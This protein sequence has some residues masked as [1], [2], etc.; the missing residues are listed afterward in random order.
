[1]IC[2]YKPCI[3][4]VKEGRIYCS[5]EHSFK[6]ATRR[7]QY[8]ETAEFENK[9]SIEALHGMEELENSHTFIIRKLQS[10]LSGEERQIV[11]NWKALVNI[12]LEELDKLKYFEYSR[13]KD[14]Y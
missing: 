8:K 13:G 10:Q 7:R 9:L 4:K 5:R 3:K 12:R 14:G 1:M 2:R 11:E 6:E